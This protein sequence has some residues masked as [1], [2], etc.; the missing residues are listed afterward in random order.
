[1]MYRVQIQSSEKLNEHAKGF[2]FED[3]RKWSS[4]LFTLN[5]QILELLWFTRGIDFHRK[6]NSSGVPR[7]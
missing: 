4:C 7:K 2:A 1:M 6:L 5:F 3:H